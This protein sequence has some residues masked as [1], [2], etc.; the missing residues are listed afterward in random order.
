MPI[1]NVNL[2][3]LEFWCVRFQSKMVPSMMIEFITASLSLIELY[4]DDF[5]D[6]NF[7]NK[8]VSSTIQGRFGVLYRIIW[9]TMNKTQIKFWKAWSIWGIFHLGRSRQR[10]TIKLYTIKKFYV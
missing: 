6:F 2:N 3:H 8:I 4:V 1:S 9:K 10:I 7:R 5:D